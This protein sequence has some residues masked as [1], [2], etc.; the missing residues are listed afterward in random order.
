M[1]RNTKKGFTLVELV[2]VIAVIAILA[3]VLIPTFSGIITKANNS[4]DLQE[5]RNT[6]SAALIDDYT[7]SNEGTEVYIKVKGGYVKF[8]SGKPQLENAN[9]ADDYTIDGTGTFTPATADPAT[10]AKL[11][12]G[13]LVVEGVTEVK[14]NSIYKK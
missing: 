9:V 7:L 11:T 4:A 6:F 5:A 1:K 2:I 12:I 3:A 14:A 8:L 10:P 13:T